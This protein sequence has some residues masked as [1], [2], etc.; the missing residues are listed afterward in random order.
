V[1]FVNSDRAQQE[2]APAVVRVV[3]GQARVL[4]ARA[5]ATLLRNL[6]GAVLAMAQSWRPTQ[7]PASAAGAILRG[8]TA[9]GTAATARIRV[10][11]V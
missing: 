9:V 4:P 11:I 5:S 8:S 1:P 10:P 3:P 2:T 7:S 6:P